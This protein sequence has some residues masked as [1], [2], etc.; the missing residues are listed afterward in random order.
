MMADEVPFGSTAYLWLLAV[1]LGARGMDFLSTWV[2]TPLLVLEGNPIAQRLGW[3]WGSLVNIG[4]CFGFALWPLPAVIVS[5]TSLL[6]AAHN[7]QSAWLMRTMGEESY[8]D[9]HVHQIQRA[10]GPLI[11]ACL[12]GQSLLYAIV[13][14]ALIYFSPVMQIPWGIGIGLFA[15]S[16]AVAAYTGLAIARIRRAARV[17]EPPPRSA[18]LSE[19]AT[20]PKYGL[21]EQAS[22]IAE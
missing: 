22:Q 11:L 2:A 18:P 15:Y 10:S 5:T 4:L 6:V 17:I 1:L 14:T 12:A 13:G 16:V 7:F 8:R 9:W 3:R 19:D 21:A 20:L